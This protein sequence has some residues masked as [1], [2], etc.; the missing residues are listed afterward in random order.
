MNE[1]LA[2][3]LGCIDNRYI[4]Q[5]A[6]KKRKKKIFLSAVA[7]VL[8]L[9]VLTNLPTI[10]FVISAKAV[11][12]AEGTQVPDRDED[13]HAYLDARLAV[14]ENAREAMVYMRPFYQQTSAQFLA[15]ETE[16]QIW[17]P[18]NAAIA[19]AAVAETADGTTRQELLDMLGAEDVEELRDYISATWESARKDDGHNFSVLANSLW[20]DE[21]LGYDQ[22]VM[23]TLAGE[24]HASVYQGD[25]GSG[26]ANKAIQNWV[27]N[28]TGGLL[29]NHSRGIDLSA[30]A[31]AIDTVLALAST[32]HIQAKWSEEFSPAWNSVDVFHG[33]VSD[34]EVTFMNKKEAEMNYYWGE[35]YGAVSLWLENNLKMWFFLP[36][37]GKTVA[38]VLATDEYLDSM[39]PGVAEENDHKWMKVNLT[40]PKFDISSAMDLKDGLEALGLTEIFDPNGG[41]FGDTFDTDLPIFISRVNQASR[42]S[43]DEEGVTAVSYIELAWGAGA[44]EP[45]QEI[46]DFVLDRPFVFAI[47]TSEGVPLFVGTINQL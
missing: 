21:D 35:S 36:D 5:A 34:T 45:P 19:L 14:E 9:V 38:D 40:V 47:A 41:D 1:K 23:D 8:A 12:I 42:V 20:L 13:L 44:A 43:I 28:N 15:D 7:A 24:Y 11:A 4:T 29:R 26:R 39:H 18:A 6:K 33:S 27:N 46:I 37:E 2:Q 3:A 16:N 10:P 30:Q 32:V 25:L 31:P 22:S 17:S